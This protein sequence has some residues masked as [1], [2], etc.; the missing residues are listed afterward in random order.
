MARRLNRSV[1]VSYAE[2]N[3]ILRSTA[4]PNDPRFA[5]LYGLNNVGQT[6]GRVDADIDAPEGWDAA[7]LG[8]FPPRAEWG[9]SALSTPGSTRPIQS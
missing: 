5:E 3:F 2:P 8:S 6:G 7:G 4:V 1:L 9:R